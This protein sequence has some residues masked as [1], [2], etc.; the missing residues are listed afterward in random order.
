MQGCDKGM[1][2]ILIVAGVFL[3]AS[4]FGVLAYNSTFPPIKLDPPYAYTPGEGVS[5]LYAFLF[6]FVTSF[7]FFG[8]SA[9]IALGVEAVK[10][11]AYV[12]SQ[13][14][15]VTHALFLIPAFLAS[16]SATYLG[17]GLL[18]DFQGTGLWMDYARKSA[19]YLVAALLLWLLVLFGR[20]LLAPLIS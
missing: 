19:H 8:F 16:V 1:K 12:S 15:P 18:K 9:P 6:V 4:F 5:E 11:A 7:L 17:Q 14:V 10:T 3:A 2:A 20:G 13:A